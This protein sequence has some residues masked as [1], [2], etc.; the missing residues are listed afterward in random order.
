M[1]GDVIVKIAR[2]S[3]AGFKSIREI[4]TLFEAKEGTK[5]EIEISRSGKRSKLSLTLESYI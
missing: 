5:Y 2:R 3:A 4:M 1:P